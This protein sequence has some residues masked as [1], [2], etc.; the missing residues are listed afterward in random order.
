MQAPESQRD[1]I[2]RIKRVLC[3]KI[4]FDDDSGVSTRH[5]SLLGLH[6]M[7]VEPGLPGFARSLGTAVV[8]AVWRRCV[9]GESRGLC[10]TRSSPRLFFH[11][12]ATNRPQCGAMVQRG[13]ACRCRP[14]R[15]V[16]SGQVMPA[17]MRMLHDPVPRI[18]AHTANA[19]VNFLD[20]AEA[21]S[22]GGG[23]PPVDPPVAPAPQPILISP[24]LMCLP[25]ALSPLLFRQY[26]FGPTLG[27]GGLAGVYKY[28]P[29]MVC[30]V[31]GVAAPY[32]FTVRSCAIYHPRRF[33][34]NT[35]QYFLYG[36]KKFG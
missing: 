18:V 17:L 5:C 25:V 36:E 15:T 22:M 13:G 14:S 20:E 2:R 27:G 7:R 8:Y 9:S 24:P 10:F 32:L 23:T 6:G 29:C 30:V 11:F 16:P 31:R 12:H 28:M 35:R 3:H 4:G 1:Y 21:R 33:F 26:C 19:L 34:D